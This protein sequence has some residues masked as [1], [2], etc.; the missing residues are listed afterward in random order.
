MERRPNLEAAF[1][2]GFVQEGF[3]VTP[4]PVLAFLDLNDDSA[5]LLTL[6]AS[7]LTLSIFSQVITQSTMN[8]MKKCMKTY[9][10]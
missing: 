10:R 4:E 7:Y 2:A 9:D 3:E 6:G 1:T 8:C 5:S